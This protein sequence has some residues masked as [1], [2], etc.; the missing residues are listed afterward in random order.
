[1]LRCVK[2]VIFLLVALS[3]LLA[4]QDRTEFPT[5]IN[6][7]LPD[8]VPA[9][10]DVGSDY[11]VGVH[12]F[13]GWEIDQSAGGFSRWDKIMPFPDR[14]PMIGCYDEANP[15][16]TDWEI[17][18]AVE[19][20]I[21]FFVYCWYRRGQNQ[22]V[23][24]ETM[25]L[26]HAIHDGLFHARYADKIKFAIMWENQSKGLSGI[27]SMED[28]QTNL[29][30]FW[31]ETY[32]KRNN[33]LKIDNQPVLYVYQHKTLISDLG[34]VK[35]ARQAIDWMKQ[36]AKKAGFA[37]LICMAEYRENDK[38]VLQ[39]IAD[40]G[41]DMAFAYCWHPNEQFP[42]A[43]QAMDYQMQTMTE[44]KQHNAIPFVTTASTM[45]D[46][47]P[48]ENNNPKTPWVYRPLL[49]R[50]RLTPVEFRGL[51]QSIK[52]FM[53]DLPANSLGRR[54]MLLDNWNEWDEG[55]YII[56][57]VY[58]GFG[59][60][61]A[62]HQVFTKQDNMPDH[63]SPQMLGLGPY[64]QKYKEL[65]KKINEQAPIVG[66]IRWDAW[67]GD[68]GMPGQAVEK[69]LGPK[70][71]H[72]RLPFYGQRL[73]DSTVHVRAN[74]QDIMDRE[75]ELA[76]QAGLRYW[77]F[78][79]YEPDNPMTI[80][81]LDLYRS[82]IQRHKINFC[83]I[84]QMMADKEKLAAQIKRFIGYFKEPGYQ[85][86]LNGRP[87]VYLFNPGGIEK[88]GRLE[89]TK[90][91]FAALRQAA[92]AAGIPDPYLVVQVF[93]PEDGKRFM[94]SL[95]FDAVSAYAT[96]G[97]GIKA[98]YADLAAYTETWWTSVKN[99]GVP[100]VPLLMSGWD[101]RPRVIHPVPWEKEQKPGA[102]VEKYYEAPKPAELAAHVQNGLAWIKDHAAAAPAQA[103][104][105]Y[106]WNETDEGGWLVPTVSEGTARLDAIGGVLKKGK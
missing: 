93:N 66:A 27:S 87:L 50:W 70:E 26:E 99:T 58:G 97:N 33:Y 80:G 74:T 21:D 39:E 103:L 106:A 4:A 42:S 90:A 7:P 105:I 2:L 1:M 72:Y 49:K 45:W 82:S 11:L 43:Q 36:A 94:E 20:G 101:R 59:Y 47:K 88:G 23:T 61:Q 96:Q 95:A 19:H 56:P 83:L 55:H 79:T 22:P 62:V 63:R 3:G 65:R 60:L 85:T 48:R 25:F 89:Q 31:M 16:V 40:C 38:K 81:G 76:Y 28:L 35:Q 29:F 34:G 68:A 30:P 54:M 78:V 18:W 69:A 86:V 12:H 10:Q 71:W 57:H 41:F 64:D 17:K 6:T 73:S 53:A 98:P 5:V 102:G 46:P 24:R 104:L 52:T 32:F 91:G 8:Y 92:L 13:P 100:I 67:H 15:E 44:W 14:M 84:T 9:P 37:G 51:L 77:A 75:I